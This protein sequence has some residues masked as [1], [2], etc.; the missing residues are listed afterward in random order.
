[1]S[2]QGSLKT[3]KENPAPQRRRHEAIN[4]PALP[5]LGGALAQRSSPGTDRLLQTGSRRGRL[6]AG[7]QLSMLPGWGEEV[8][9][10]MRGLLGFRPDIFLN[11][12]VASRTLEF[13]EVE[14]AGKV[15]FC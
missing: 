15:C 12:K 9:V 6:R 3:P 13:K 10:L 7:H 1:M 2:V 8:W 14:C 4:I 5:S 11:T